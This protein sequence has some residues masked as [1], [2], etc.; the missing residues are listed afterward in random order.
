METN[1]ASVTSLSEKLAALDLSD[2]ER[3]VLHVVLAAG[4]SQSEVEGFGANSPPEPGGRAYVV[5]LNKQMKLNIM[6][7]QTT[8]AHSDEEVQTR[9][10]SS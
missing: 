8:R 1:E 4:E 9:K 2:E 5:W 7:G 6:L 10:Y 3:S